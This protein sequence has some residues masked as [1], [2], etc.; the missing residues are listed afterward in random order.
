MK[1]FLDASKALLPGLLSALLCAG[2]GPADPSTEVDANNEFAAAEQATPASAETRQSIGVSAWHYR[3]EPDGSASIEGRDER[4]ALEVALRARVDEAG[5]VTYARIAAGGAEIAAE[6]AVVAAF[7][8]DVAD[9]QQAEAERAAEAM[10]ASEASSFNLPA[11]LER[12]DLVAMEPGS[13]APGFEP[14]AL[15][16]DQR[17]T[18]RDIMKCMR[19]FAGQAYEWNNANLHSDCALKPTPWNSTDVMK[20]FDGVHGNAEMVVIAFAG[21]HGLGD[22]ARDAQSLSWT[23][24]KNPLNPALPQLGNVGRGWHV[25]WNNQVAQTHLTGILD[26]YKWH[27]RT[28]NRQLQIVVTGHSLG[29]VTATLAG[30]DIAQYL[31]GNASPWQVYVYAFNPPRLGFTL[32]RDNYQN[33]LFESRCPASGNQICLTMRQFTRNGDPV[34]S[35][36]PA[37]MHPVWQTAAGSATVGAGVRAGQNLGYCPQLNAAGVSGP[38]PWAAL[39]N[40]KL[41]T[42]DAQIDQMS[43]NQIDCMFEHRW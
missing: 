4:G 39:A 40:H 31:R 38:W 30:Y 8:A 16:V 22:L 37:M 6:D 18:R 12:E 21:T 13:A 11:A 34:Q 35:V 15:T 7:R 1:T 24:H 33:A 14:Q 42:W 10:P 29:A 17:K 41:E 26:W 25:R 9:P 32:P 28:N 19:R 3:Q 2:C 36:P 20:V 5:E 23:W 43:G 27:A